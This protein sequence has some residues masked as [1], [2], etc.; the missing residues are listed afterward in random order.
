MKVA[1]GT[2]TGQAPTW[3]GATREN[4]G[5]Y[6]TEEQRR[7]AGCIAGRMPRDFHHGLLV[8]GVYWPGGS[9]LLGGMR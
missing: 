6:S 8:S 2:E 5:V 9:S 1:C 4:S 3:Q 7:E